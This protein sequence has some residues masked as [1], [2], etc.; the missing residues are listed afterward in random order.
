MYT[1]YVTTPRTTLITSPVEGGGQPYHVFYLPTITSLD[2]HDPW[3][4]PETFTF[5]VRKYKP[6]STCQTQTQNSKTLNRLGSRQNV[7]LPGHLLLHIERERLARSIHFEKSSCWCLLSLIYEQ[8]NVGFILTFCLVLCA[9]SQSYTV[10]HSV[11]DTD[12]YAHLYRYIG[13]WWRSTRI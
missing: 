9:F 5:R 8:H 10:K 4:T 1:A 12:T 2:Y 13:V 11:K 3:K 6:V 7:L